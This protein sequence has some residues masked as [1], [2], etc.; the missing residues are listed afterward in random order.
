MTPSMF[1]SSG[2]HGAT[3]SAALTIQSPSSIEAIIHRGAISIPESQK[4]SYYSGAIV[5][6]NA[7]QENLRYTIASLLS[8]QANRTLKVPLQTQTTQT[9][10]STTTTKTTLNTQATLPASS[11]TSPTTGTTSLVWEPLVISKDRP[12][13]Y[14]YPDATPTT[15]RAYVRLLSYIGDPKYKIT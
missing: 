1:M 2:A 15:A 12:I 11:S 3:T 8:F 10:T 6:L 13:T 9:T 4:A 7:L 14:Y 5:A